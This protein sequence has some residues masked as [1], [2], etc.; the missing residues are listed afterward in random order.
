MR[1]TQVSQQF[2]YHSMK[3]RITGIQHSQQRIGCRF[4]E[5]PIIFEDRRFGESKI[6]WKESAAAI[7]V[8]FRL[9]ID[10]LFRVRVR[11]RD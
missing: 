8:L 10:R 2:D 4:A 1:S 11:R 3:G 5:T 6:S 7:W 9:A